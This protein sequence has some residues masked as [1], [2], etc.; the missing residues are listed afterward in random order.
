[1]RGL[2]LDRPRRPDRRRHARPPRRFRG[3]PAARRPPGRRPSRRMRYTSPPGFDTWLLHQYEPGAT[4]NAN[5]V[6]ALA[7]DAL[8]QAGPR[9]LRTPRDLVTLLR[10]HTVTRDVYA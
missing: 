7:A 1:M 9:R 6:A 2:C 5:P 4:Y 10:E 8:R 3:S